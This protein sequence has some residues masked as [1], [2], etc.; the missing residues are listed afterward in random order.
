MLA[1][2]VILAALVTTA[3]IWHFGFLRSIRRSIDKSAAVRRKPMTISGDPLW[4]AYHRRRRDGTWVTPRVD[5]L[6]VRRETRK[7]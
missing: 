6:R 1:I 4:E 3:L 7:P 2:A 5:P